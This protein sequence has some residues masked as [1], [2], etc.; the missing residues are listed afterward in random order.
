MATTFPHMCRDGHIEIG[1]AD[2]EHELCPMCRLRNEHEALVTA[3]RVIAMQFCER[4]SLGG[5][6]CGGDDPYCASCYAFSAL[7]QVEE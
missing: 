5:K 7:A 6:P 4:R 2:S 1:H 3:L